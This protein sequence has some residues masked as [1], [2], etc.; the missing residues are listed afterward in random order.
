MFADVLR[1]NIVVGTSVGDLRVGDRV[2]DGSGYSRVFFL[3]DH[4]EVKQTVVLRWNS[5]S[6]E[7]TTAHRVPVS[8][9]FPLPFSL[10]HSPPLPCILHLNVSFFGGQHRPMILLDLS[11]CPPSNFFSIFLKLSLHLV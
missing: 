1:G 6:L 9:S 7:L 11:S 4:Q 2:R 10:T 3:H 8:L 5:G